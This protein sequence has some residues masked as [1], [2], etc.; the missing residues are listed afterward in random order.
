MVRGLLLVLAV[1]AQTLAAQGADS[2]S[3]DT[4]PQMGSAPTGRLVH[5][6]DGAEEAQLLTVILDTAVVL[7][8]EW[9]RPNEASSIFCVGFLDSLGLHDPHPEVLAGVTAP[10]QVTLRPATQCADREPTISIAGLGFGADQQ[11]AKATFGLACGELCGGTQWFVELR[12]RGSRWAI[13][14]IRWFGTN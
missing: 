13:S 12:R 14:V 7:G 8:S 2:L 10:P 11:T 9:M 6:F 1:S 3:P 5:L 4:L